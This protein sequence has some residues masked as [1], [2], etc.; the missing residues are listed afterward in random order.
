MVDPNQG[1]RS[2]KI[3]EMANA[4]DVVHKEPRTEYR[5]PFHVRL[6]RQETRCCMSLRR[7]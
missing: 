3:S 5:N 2:G 6:C 1:K 4:V 7:K